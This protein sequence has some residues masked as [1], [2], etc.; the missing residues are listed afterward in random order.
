MLPDKIQTMDKAIRKFIEQEGALTDL[1]FWVQEQDLDEGE[2]EY[3]DY[4]ARLLLKA[5]NE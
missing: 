5:L 3:L 2:I 1:R 4:E